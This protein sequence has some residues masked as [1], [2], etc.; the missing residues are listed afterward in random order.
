MHLATGSPATSATKP[1]CTTYAQRQTIFLFGR[2]L[3]SGLVYDLHIVREKRC[4]PHVAAPV[5]CVPRSSSGMVLSWKDF[6]TSF[7]INAGV[8]VAVFV[9]FTAIRKLPWLSNFYAAKRKLSIP[10]RCANGAA[11][12]KQAMYLCRAACFANAVS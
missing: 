11:L 4:L 1:L 2:V 9:V 3:L 5:Q 12:P 7:G 8:T 10:F 6:G